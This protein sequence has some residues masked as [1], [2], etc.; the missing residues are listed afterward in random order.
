MAE[1]RKKLSLTRLFSGNGISWRE[2]LIDQPAAYLALA[3]ER[4]KDLPKT[5]YDLGFRFAGEGKWMDAIFRFKVV[6]FLNPNYPNANY[7]LG[8]CYMRT[9][10]AVEAKAAFIKALQQNPAN[11][12]ATFMLASL[13]ANAVPAGQR[14]TRMPAD[15]VTGFFAAQAEGYDITEA[16]NRYQAG[17]VIY[18]LIKPQV[19]TETPVVLDLGCG[20]GIAARPWRAAAASIRGVDITPSMLALADKATHAEKK[21]FDGLSTADLAQLPA[22]LTNGTADI[23]LLVNVVQFIGELSTTL[24][25]AAQ[26]LKPGGMLVVTVEPFGLPAGYGLVAA[27][28][29]FGHSNAYVK[30]MAASAGLTP[31]SE[32]SVELYV[33]VPAQALVF[34]K[35]TK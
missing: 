32:S 10:K 4:M 25:G 11:V 19:K 3:R 22:E 28:S 26:A 16:N 7:N 21:L 6:L 30:Q 31:V 8:C 27:T 35:G 24:N 1:S 20:S 34:T 13:D 14:P 5:N 15:M 2:W 12:D 29:R 9:G 23:V 17:K 33:G 18:D